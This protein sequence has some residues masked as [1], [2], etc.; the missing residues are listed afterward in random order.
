VFVQE[1]MVNVGNVICIAL[2]QTSGI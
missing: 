1:D 2:R